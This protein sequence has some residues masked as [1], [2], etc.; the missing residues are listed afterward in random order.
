MAQTV[1]LNTILS[2]VKQLDTED[3]LTLLQKIAAIIKGKSQAQ[4]ESPK[5]SALSGLGSE[6][7]KGRE[8]IDQ[9]LEEERQW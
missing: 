1:P 8:A 3:Q 4:K 6:I 5:L 2:Q 9:Y 7:W